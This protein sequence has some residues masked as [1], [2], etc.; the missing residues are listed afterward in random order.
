[1]TTVAEEVTHDQSYNNIMCPKASLYRDVKLLFF[2]VA[3]FFTFHFVH[4]QFIS[5]EVP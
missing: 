5:A 3:N 4:V 1:M 2:A